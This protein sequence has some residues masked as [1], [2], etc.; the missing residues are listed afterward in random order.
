MGH[1]ARETTRKR[2]SGWTDEA[3]SPAANQSPRGGIG[4]SGGRLVNGNG[5]IVLASGNGEVPAVPTPGK[6]LASPTLGEAAMRLHVL[7]GWGAAKR[8]LL[9]PC[10]PQSLADQDLDPGSGPGR[11]G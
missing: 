4:Q 6:P 8:R 9:L 1:V 2:K 3:L 7:P 10:D 11:G 5:A